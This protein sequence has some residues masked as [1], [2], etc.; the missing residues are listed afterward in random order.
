MKIPVCELEF[1]KA[2]ELVKAEQEAQVVSAIRN[3]IRHVV[4]LAHGWNTDKADAGQFYA[5]FLKTVE[6]RYILAVQVF[7]PSKKFD[8]P[9]FSPSNPNE[10]VRDVGAVVDSEADPMQASVE[11][12]RVTI[13]QKAE[14]P[15]G[16]AELLR[17]FRLPWRRASALRDGL[18]PLASGAARLLNLAT[19]Y[20]MKDR[21]GKIG[22]EALS[23]LLKRIQ[24]QA[25]AATKFHFAGHSFG[26]RMLTATVDGP[27]RLNLNSLLLLQ[28]AYSHNG[29]SVNFDG[30]GNNGFF[31]KVITESKVRGPIVITHSRND[32]AVGLAYPLA[33]RL[34]GANAAR[35]GDANDIYGGMGANGAQ[36]V[37]VNNLTLGG[38]NDFRSP[39]STIFNMNG[40]A[41]IHSHGDVARP[42]TAALLSALIKQFAD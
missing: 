27:N 28:A 32:E 17:S 20:V 22:R 34:N 23:P 7:W 18:S 8:F 2:G 1:D 3:G 39:D 10:F 37:A 33:S 14:H 13:S 25:P 40:D 35:L 41:I 30:R 31:H 24:T 15:G 11:E 36:H 21:A 9:P 16:A 38:I 26:A 12:G 4:V 5:D 42:E 6:G 29:L 19:Y